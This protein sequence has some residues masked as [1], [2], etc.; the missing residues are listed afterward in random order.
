MPPPRLRVFTT[1]VIE[2]DL[3]RLAAGQQ[4]DGGWTVPYDTASPAAALEW[5]GYATVAA[6]TTLAPHLDG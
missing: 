6:I 3:A 1:E 4:R 2:A 5:R